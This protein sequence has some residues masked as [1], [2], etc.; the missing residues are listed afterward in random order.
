MREHLQAQLL[1]PVLTAP[2]RQHV[3]RADREPKARDISPC[4]V[5]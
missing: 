5:C 2:T 3:L 4:F 1:T